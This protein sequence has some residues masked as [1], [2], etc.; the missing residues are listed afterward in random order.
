MNVYLTLGNEIF[1]LLV[2]GQTLVAVIRGVNLSIF[3]P[4]DSLF[5]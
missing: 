5:K 3:Q 2:D 4:F 1:K